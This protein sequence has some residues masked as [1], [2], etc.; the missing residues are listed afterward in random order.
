MVIFIVKLL[1]LGRLSIRLT[2]TISVFFLNS[3]YKVKSMVLFFSCDVAT[4]VY[5]FVAESY[6][7]CVR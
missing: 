1:L 5:Y 7:R 3:H 2:S 6:L 4:S